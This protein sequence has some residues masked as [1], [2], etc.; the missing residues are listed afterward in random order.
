MAKDGRRPLG[1]LLQ[2]QQHEH[3]DEKAGQAQFASST[4]LSDEQQRGYEAVLRWF[5][6]NRPHKL[7][8]GTNSR[9][10]I[11]PMYVLVGIGGT[12]K[13][14]L[15]G[16]IASHLTRDAKVAFCAFTGKASSVLKRSLESNGVRPDFCGTIHRLIYKPIINEETGIIEGW[17][18]QESL[19][20]DL[21]VLDEASMVSKEIADDLT[22][23]GIPILA[24]GDEFQLS[25]VTDGEDSSILRKPDFSLKTI[26]RQ[27]EGNPIIQLCTTVRNGGDWKGFIKSNVSDKIKYINKMDLT[28]LVME[29]FDGIAD[30][31]MSDDPMLICGT[32]RTR[33]MLNKAVRCQ[34]GDQFLVKGERIISLRNHYMG[35]LMLAN[36]FL[37]KVTGF[38]YSPN[39][40]NINANVLFADE[41]LELKDGMIGRAQ[42]GKEKMPEVPYLDGLSIDYGTAKTCHRAQGGSARHVIG[43]IER[44]QGDEIEF[45][46]WVYTLFSR[47]SDTLEVCF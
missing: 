28:E 31:P 2:T 22:S 21:I 1:L 30:K 9:Q 8:D 45:R 37:G 39:P 43:V 4:I 19:P 14:T 47:S 33:V 7:P 11:K 35:G 26:R 27:V 3:L 20:Y 16:F 42:F 15:S 34:F 25:P 41:G 10:L 17:Q 46:R 40:L 5:K 18:R 6:E 29:R 24:I 36:G 23:F 32:N 38:G 44:Y 12:G 13:T